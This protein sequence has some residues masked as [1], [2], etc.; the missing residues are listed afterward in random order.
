MIFDMKRIILFLFLLSFTFVFAKVSPGE[1]A[2]T[3]EGKLGDVG[4]NS[5]AYVEGLGVN[6]LKFQDFFM[7][8]VEFVSLGF[9][10]KGGDMAF[11]Q[12]LFFVLLFMM[13]YSIVGLVFRKFNF[14]IAF[15]ITILAFMGMD[16]GTLESVFLNYGA[17]G[18]T[19]TVVL[20]VLILLA[21]TY[22]IYEKAYLGKSSTS[23]F[24]AEMFNLVFL[25]FFG[26]FFIRYAGD[27]EKVIDI[28]RIFSGWILISLGIGQTVL[29]KGVA[30]SIRKLRV[31]D[32]RE[33]RRLAKMWRDASDKLKKEEFEYEAGMRRGGEGKT[34]GRFI[35]KDVA[36]R[37]S[38]ICG[39]GAAKKR[40]DKLN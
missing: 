8:A 25:V 37:Y 21:F 10:D 28:M 6:L 18:I 12:F 14:M 9:F 32:E 30:Q 17:M 36:K 31:G 40:F 33:K 1:V 19:V 20:P 5:D 23:P 7:G 26:V 34:R 39:P 16:E 29:Y 38:K 2:G 35:G 27:G 3:V 4:R 13:L 24:Y 15:I 22:R 11:V